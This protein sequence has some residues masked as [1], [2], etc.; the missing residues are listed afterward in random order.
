VQDYSSDEDVPTDDVFGLSKLPASK[1]P[2]TD[3]VPLPLATEA[4]PH[5]LSEVCFLF[6]DLPVPTRPQLTT[7]I[8]RIPSTKRHLLLARQTLR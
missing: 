2:R 1:R 8:R 6:T 7:V 3:E 4:A 5:V